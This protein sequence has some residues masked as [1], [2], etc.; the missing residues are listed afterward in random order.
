MSVYSNWKYFFDSFW[1]FVFRNGYPIVL[2]LF[3]IWICIGIFPLTCYESDSMHVIAGCNIMYNQGLTFS[4]VYSYL[5]EM[6]PLVTYTVVG[7]AFSV[8]Y[9]RVFCHFDVSQF[10]DFCG[11]VFCLRS[12]QVIRWKVLCGNGVDGNRSFI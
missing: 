11:C 2:V 5:Y 10:G 1:K 9:S 7:F 8:S 4:P 3:F 6:Q 12:K